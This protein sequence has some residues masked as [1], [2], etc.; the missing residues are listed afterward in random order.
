M[1]DAPTEQEAAGQPSPKQDSESLTSLSIRLG[2]P[3]GGE[4]HNTTR[5]VNSEIRDDS[6]ANDRHDTPSK[7]SSDEK[8]TTDDNRTM[9]FEDLDPKDQ[10]RRLHEI[11]GSPQEPSVADF[12]K[13]PEL[14]AHSRGLMLGSYFR[15]VTAS[16]DVHTAGAAE[17]ICNMLLCSYHVTEL[18]FQLEEQEDKVAALK[19]QNGA[20][21]AQRDKLQAKVIELQNKE[22]AQ[23]AQ[24]EGAKAQKESLQA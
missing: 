14:P 4:A 5:A 20:L 23:K 13:L 3:D 6:R 15:G 21:K 7:T 24:N 16:M 11:N 8:C 12:K 17:K 18:G 1:G 22:K 9:R 19:A 2:L 10:F